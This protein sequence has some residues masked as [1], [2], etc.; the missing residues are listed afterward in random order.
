MAHLATVGTHAVNGVAAL[1]SDLLKKTVLRE[2]AELW[3]E[4]FHNIT[5]GVTPRRFL[6]LS[7][8]ALA[9]LLDETLGQGWVTDLGRLEA[10]EAHAGDAAFRERWR[11]VK[12]LNKDAAR[13]EFRNAP[14]SSWIPMRCS[15]SRSSA[16]TNTSASI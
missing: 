15:T 10:L 2:F 13:A 7:N 8:P 12:R 14:A 11:D 9:A 6:V 16:S 5:N 1:H 3:P 4:R